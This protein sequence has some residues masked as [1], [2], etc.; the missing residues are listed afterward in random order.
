MLTI[1]T[2]VKNNELGFIALM[3]AIIISAILMMVVILLSYSGW[4]SRY[5]ILNSEY[6]ERS[7]AVAEACVD[8][9]FLELINNADYTGNATTSVAGN[10]CYISAVTAL[11]S[12]RIFTT[13]AI[14]KGTHTF[15]GVTFDIS[16]GSVSSWE[17]LAT[18]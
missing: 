7:T 5:N 3:S 18:Y 6:K 2:K 15:L 14:Y 9:A 8:H 17:E 4:N 11:G 13:R 1:E 16:D 10:E 12:Q